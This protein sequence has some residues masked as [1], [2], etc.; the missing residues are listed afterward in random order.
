MPQV[1]IVQGDAAAAA[2][3]LRDMFATYLTGPSLTS[4]LLDSP[5]LSQA[6]EEALV[7]HCERILVVSLE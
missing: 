5:L 3:G 7:K 4:V 6:R 1:R 2:I